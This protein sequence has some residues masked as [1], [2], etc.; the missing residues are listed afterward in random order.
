MDHPGSWRGYPGERGVNRR[1]AGLT[2]PRKDLDHD[3][4]PTAARARR[5]DI[6]RLV[7]DIVGRRRD[8]E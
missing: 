6:D 7:R 8:R 4:A 2:P 3:H 1:R 5:A